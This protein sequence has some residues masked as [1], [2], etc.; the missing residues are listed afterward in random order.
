MVSFLVPPKPSDGNFAMHPIIIFL[1]IVSSV[2]G[3]LIS[4]LELIEI[5]LPL[6]RYFVY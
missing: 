5:L 6:C 1:A 2:F 4:F 3:S